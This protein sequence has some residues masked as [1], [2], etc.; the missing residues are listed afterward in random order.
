MGRHKHGRLVLRTAYDGHALARF[1]QEVKLVEHRSAG[2]R[3]IP[4]GDPIKPERAP[5]DR[6]V[7]GT[8]RY[9]IQRI[10]PHRYL[11]GLLCIPPHRYLDGIQRIPPHRYLDNLLWRR[12]L[13]DGCG[14]GIEPAA[15]GSLLEQ[16]EDG[17]GRAQRLLDA[18][19]L[20]GHV[21]RSR[22]DEL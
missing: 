18:A 4:E 20:V 13:D 9:G 11:D 5:L 17:G 7:P 6:N 1:N 22:A 15:H 3:R 19:P 10:P 14:C 21:G 2:A 16:G 12:G 8:P